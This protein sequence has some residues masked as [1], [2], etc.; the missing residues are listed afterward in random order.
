MTFSDGEE[1]L[2]IVAAFAQDG[3]RAGQRVLC[4]TQ[5]LTPD[6]MAAAMRQRGLPVDDAVQQGRLTVASSGD[7]FLT[8]GRFVPDRTLDALSGHLDHAERQGFDGL[9]VASD[10][11]WALGP[12]PGSNSSSSTRVGWAGCSPTAGPPR[13]ASTTGRVSTA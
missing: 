8:D 6:A 7:V 4:L 10:M 13:S 1:R 12:V 5:A 11:G 9:R 2:D 3:L